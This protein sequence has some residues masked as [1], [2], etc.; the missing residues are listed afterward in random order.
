M[1]IKNV[2]LVEDALAK[3]LGKA[4]QYESG[5]SADDFIP[6]EFM[7]HESREERKNK[8]QECEWLLRQALFGPEGYFQNGKAVAGHSA[9]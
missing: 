8:I 3:V 7:P 1:D 4:Y 2:S 5:F 9:S 6:Y